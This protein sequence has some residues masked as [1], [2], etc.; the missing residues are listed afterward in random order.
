MQL[1]CTYCQTMFAIGREET[2]AAL[3]SMEENHLK[4]YDAHCPRCR[5]ANRVERFRLE[6]SYPTWKADL[7]AMASRAE[8]SGPGEGGAGESAPT[9]TPTA[10]AVPPPPPAPPEMKKAHARTHGHA[11]EK[12][13]K[14]EQAPVQE[15][16]PA[17]NAGKGPLG[18]SQAKQGTRKPAP[19]SAKRKPASRP[20]ATRVKP[21]KAVRPAPAKKKKPALK[22]KK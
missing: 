16:M 10:P 2:L 7:Q 13:S 15:V 6:I 8:P 5:R 21:R 22:K 14:L 11:A 18:A 3:E 19:A 12:L 4:Y 9:P 1:R 20:K 17:V